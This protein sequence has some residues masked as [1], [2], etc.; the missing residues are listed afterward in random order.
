MAKTEPKFTPGPWRVCH[1]N[2]ILII[3]DR[4][5]CSP[6]YTPPPML[7][8]NVGEILCDA[9]ER[10]AN[11]A[12]VAAAPEMYAELEKVE[13]ILRNTTDWLERK[14]GN[15]LDVALLRNE[16]ENIDA[17]LAKARGE[18]SC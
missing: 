12:L 14:F 10:Q 3:R 8:A 4:K 9:M 1:E 2:D 5:P 13:W 15:I 18:V 6:S 16:A 11:A 17:L 7:V